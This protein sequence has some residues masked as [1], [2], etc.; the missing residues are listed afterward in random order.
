M[1][2][3]FGEALGVPGTVDEHLDIELVDGLVQALRKR[4]TRQDAFIHFHPE[5]R[6]VVFLQQTPGDAGA[7]GQ[8]CHHATQGGFGFRPVMLD[9]VPDVEPETHRRDHN[10]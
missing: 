1:V 10:G 3:V 7:A 4:I 6:L 5:P 2:F 8:A 9:A